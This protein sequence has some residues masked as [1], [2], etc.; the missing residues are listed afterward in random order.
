M[1]DKETGLRKL[2]R[3][4]RRQFRIPENL[5]H[6]SREDFRK[7]ER[8]FLKYALREGFRDHPNHIR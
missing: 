2:I 3:R 8:E 1:T 6:Y 4:Y 5:N 7:A